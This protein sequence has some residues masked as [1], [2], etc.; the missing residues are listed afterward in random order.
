M[1]NADN[2]NASSHSTASAQNTGIICRDMLP[3]KTLSQLQTLPQLT[4]GL[5]Q[6]GGAVLD[7][8]KPTLVKFWASWCPLC[9]DARETEDWRQD[10]K[11]AGLN[12][13]TVAGQAIL[14]KSQV[15]FRDWYSGV[16]GDYRT[17]LYLLTIG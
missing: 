2:G 17:Y 10:P 12:V 8:N 6:T 11:F 14:T 9:S 16:Q 5:G 13:V 4:E 3:S 1:S 7:A 15:D